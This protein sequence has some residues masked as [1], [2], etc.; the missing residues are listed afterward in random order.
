[1]FEMYVRSL[2]PDDETFRAFMSK[3]VTDRGIEDPGGAPYHMLY[4]IIKQ[5]IREYLQRPK[6]EPHQNK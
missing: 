6:P 4:K 5:G 3:Y 1:M 2:N